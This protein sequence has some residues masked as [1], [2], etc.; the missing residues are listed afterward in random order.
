MW[1]AMGSFLGCGFLIKGGSQSQ[2]LWAIVVGAANGTAL[3]FGLGPAAEKGAAALS[4]LLAGT[5]FYFIAASGLVIVSTEAQAIDRADI[6]LVSI[7]LVLGLAFSI[8]QAV[9]VRRRN[10]RNALR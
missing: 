8:A 6:F 2:F 9:R 7:F 1:V 10:G 4:G 3:G 5:P